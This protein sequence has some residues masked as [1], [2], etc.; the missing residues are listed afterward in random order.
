[1][2]TRL[3]MA[4]RTFWL[5]CGRHDEGAKGEWRAATYSELALGTSLTQNDPCALIAW[6]SRGTWDARGPS[7]GS[8]VSPTCTRLWRRGPRA[9]LVLRRAGFVNAA[10]ADA[11]SIIVHNQ[12]SVSILQSNIMIAGNRRLENRYNDE[13]QVRACALTIRANLGGCLQR[14][15]ARCGLGTCS[16]MTP[17]DI[18]RG[19]HS[20]QWEQTWGR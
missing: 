7:C 17:R 10:H 15:R 11:S 6:K 9:F 1:M 2:G 3:S 13:S 4:M 18:A 5:R 8:V 20:H 12:P 19:G 16:N 14:S